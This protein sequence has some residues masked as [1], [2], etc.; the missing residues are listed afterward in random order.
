MLALWSL[1]G[2]VVLVEDKAGEGSEMEFLTG[3]RDGLNMTLS[4]LGVSTES[5]VPL[6]NTGVAKGELDNPPPRPSSSC[7][8]RLLFR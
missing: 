3:K 6:V 7:P 5:V 1:R 8:V 2:S 4:A